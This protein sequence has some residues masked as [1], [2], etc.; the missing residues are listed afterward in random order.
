V[1]LEGR[2]LTLF[3]YADPKRLTALVVGTALIETEWLSSLQNTAARQQLRVALPYPTA[4]VPS[5]NEMR[6]A[7]DETRLPWTVAVTSVPS[8]GTGIGIE[9]LR[10]WIAGVG[11]LS[12]IVVGGAI[13]I[14]RATARELAVARLQSDFVAAVS[15]EFRTPLTSLRQIGEVLHD[16]R[17]QSD[18]RRRTYY[19]ALT[20]QTERLHHLVETLLDF[21]R[22]EAGRSP[23]QTVP[24]DLS[25]WARSVVEQFSR[26]VA[27]R[28]YTVEFTSG[29]EPL[30]VLGD[31]QALGNALW[32]LLDN[33]VKYSPDCRTVW[34]AVERIGHTAAVRVRD[35]G[36][37]VPA[38][39]QREIFG[40][41]VRG[42]EAK[43]HN[44]SGTGIGLAMVEHII[45]AHGG[46]V[47]VESQPGLGST[48][49]LE[50][51][52]QES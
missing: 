46:R 19:E 7:S 27:G 33:A 6:R 37:G 3:W 31:P 49:S 42:A 21:G 25:S 29:S 48:F 34:V 45:K 40:K 15:H 10:I 12:L 38:A 5:R 50:I 44:I 23:Y 36:I 24:L 14:A 26:D 41:F 28:G 51:P 47:R 16:G 18:E 13:V 30:D 17:I 2:D 8:P 39:E 9:R 32:N 11:V 20:R 1:S 52:C 22:M 35:R 4:S 43:R